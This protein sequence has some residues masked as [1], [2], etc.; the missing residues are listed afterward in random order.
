[1]ASDTRELTLLLNAKDL[2]A[3]ALGSMT[4]GINGLVTTA[5]NAG[6]KI[7]RGFENAVSAT[8]NAFG[9]F[10]ENVLSGQ[11][12]GAAA[13]QAGV[14]MG[15]QLAE[16]LL[17]QALE[18]LGESTLVE[19]LGGALAAGGAAIGG[20]LDTAI[21]IGMAA[22]PVVLV[23]ALVAAIVF[24][25][26]N[27]KIVQEALRVAGSIVSGILDGL[28]GLAQLILGV[29]VAAPGVIASTFGP[30][31]LGIVGWYLSIPGKLVGLGLSI[32]TTIIDGMVS[33]PG[34]LADVIRQAFAGL[35]IDIGPFHIT[36][37]GITI[38]LPNITAP[39]P[40][41]QPVH[42]HA[43]G[44]W[45][46]LN[47]PELA[48]LGDGGEPE[49]VTPMSQLQRGSARDRSMT[50]VAVPVSPS[51]LARAAERGL[52]LKLQR[53]PGAGGGRA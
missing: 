15:G 2:S 18:K 47:G 25:V 34:K 29:I 1:M 13:L 53:S 42:P 24:L 38:D 32:V 20:L 16:G 46:G 21:G 51:E 22:L 33:L 45:A 52:Y 49:L 7:A 3:K 28:K 44:G 50:W 27:P 39:A 35:K 43:A 12:L 30:M 8:A 40:G 9:N 19:A 26:N 4:S 48:L 17:G 37:S 41:A 23:G 10:T 14:F 11:D 5:E 31:I 6:R 36:G